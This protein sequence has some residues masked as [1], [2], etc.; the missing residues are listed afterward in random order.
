MIEKTAGENEAA[1]LA[2][3]PAESSKADDGNEEGAD[4]HIEVESWFVI[5]L[6]VGC[7]SGLS[8]NGCLRVKKGERRKERKRKRS[9]DLSIFCAAEGGQSEGA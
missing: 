5:L 2:R 4:W 9:R 3:Q 7:L 8:R 6:Q 1:E